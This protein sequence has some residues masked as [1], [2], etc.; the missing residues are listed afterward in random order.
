M[1]CNGIL[2]YCYLLSLIFYNVIGQNLMMKEKK[3]IIIIT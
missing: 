3:I 1:L 2:L